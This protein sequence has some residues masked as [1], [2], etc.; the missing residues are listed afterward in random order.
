LV[1]FDPSYARKRELKLFVHSGAGMLKPKR[2]GLDTVHEDNSHPS[3]SVGV[4][5]A[6]RQPHDVTPIEF[7]PLQ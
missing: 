4:Q 5:F 6:R 1:L 2:F 3:E 7:L